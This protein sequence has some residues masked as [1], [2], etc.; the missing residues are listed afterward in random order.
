MTNDGIDFCGAV[1]RKREKEEAER[2]DF[3]G[4]VDAPCKFDLPCHTDVSPWPPERVGKALA[5]LDCGG[6]HADWREGDCAGPHED[7][8][9]AAAV[10]DGSGTAHHP[11][12]ARHPR[13]GLQ[14]CVPERRTTLSNNTTPKIVLQLRRWLTM[15]TIGSNVR[16]HPRTVPSFSSRAA[17]VELRFPRQTNL[18]NLQIE[19]PKKG[20]ITFQGTQPLSGSQRQP[21][22]D[23]NV[24]RNI[25]NNGRSTADVYGG[26]NKVPGQRVQPHI[27]IQ[28]ERNFGNNGFIRGHGQLQPG[29]RGHGV[30]P[31]VGVTGGFRFRREAEP[32]GSISFQGTQPLSGPMRQPTWDLN[33][34]RNIFNNGRSTADVYGGLSKI[35]G[36]RVQPH[37]G[38][39]AER[40]F[41][42]NGF[43]RG[44]GQLQPGPRGH[45][46]SPS[47]GVTGGFRFR[48]EAEPQGSISFQGTQPLS[49]PMR[50]PTWD[51]NANRNIFN[52]GRSTADVYGG[53]SKI[54]GQR[55]Q[56][57]VGIQAERNFGNNGF[58]RGHGQ[59]QPG[60][61]GH[62]VSPSVGVT[63]GFRFRREAEPQGS[64]SFQGT[65]P[66][67]GPMRQPTWDLN[68]N[69]NIFNNGRSTADVYGGLSKIPGQR[70]QPH[71]GIQAERNFGNNG[72]IRGHGQLQPGPRGHGVSPSIGVTGGFRFKREAEP[73]GSLSFQGTQPLSGPMRQPTWDLNVN[74]NIF[75]NGRSTADVYGG[76]SKIP[77]QRVQPH[78]GIQAERNFGNNGFIRGHGQLQP[79]PRGHGVSPSVGVTGG[80]RFRREAEPQ[81]SISFQGTQPLSGPMRQPTWDLNANR[82]IFNNGRSTADVYGGL[83]KIPGQRVQPHVGIQAERNFGNNGFIR[84]HGQLQPGPRGHGVSPSVGVTGGFRFR[85]EAEPQGS[86]SF[87]GTQPLSGPMR[88]PTWDLNANRNIFNN[89]REAEDADEVE[90]T[91]EY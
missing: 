22:W 10:A 44:H 55:V 41:G 3:T 42:N 53:L 75:N 39:Q 18:P 66:L 65:Q 20:S 48:R 13:A 64:I 7:E 89:K 47:V 51:L 9:D 83:S 79:G 43:I 73:Q 72:F 52:N 15:T 80:F 35:P 76:L 33:A 6:P 30:S 5:W 56:P 63:G 68:A 4:D 24:N 84:G 31:S 81:G 32:Q 8:S 34:N 67:S 27:G 2:K 1:R 87:Q 25:L 26:L 62:G 37:V 59:L 74:R 45:G 29:P 54:P 17:D 38:I 82:N 86:I 70:V 28:A 85:R 77:G 58:I 57:H 90:P 12:R 16:D 69:R 91:E 19:E 60:P 88:Q 71:V 36:Q 61:R 78:V 14:T 50:Q 49:G 46:V 40:N 23:L 21:T 11:A